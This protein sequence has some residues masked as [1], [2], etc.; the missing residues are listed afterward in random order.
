M[1]PPNDD[2]LLRDMR[3]SARKAVA[4]IQGRS[5][6]DLERDPVLNAALERF[7]EVVGEAANR[8]S[9]DRKK[10]LPGIPWR[11]IVAMRNRLVHGY[12][13]VD[14]DVLWDVVHDDLSQTDR[15]LGHRARRVMKI[16]RRLSGTDT[17]ATRATAERG[18]VA[19]GRMPPKNST[20]GQATIVQ[21]LAVVCL[22]IAASTEAACGHGFVV[23]VSTPVSPPDGLEWSWPMALAVLFLVNLATFRI[24]RWWGWL[25]SGFRAI[26]AIALFAAIFF[27]VGSC[28]ETVQPR[29]LGIPCHI[30]WGWGWTELG[31]LF[32]GWNTISSFALVLAV[33]AASQLWKRPRKTAII[34]IGINLLVYAALCLPYITSGALAQGWVGAYARTQCSDHLE[35]HMQA[36]IHYAKEHQGKLP[37]AK[38]L[39][40]LLTELRPYTRQPNLIQESPLDTCPV[41]A[42][43]ERSP[44]RYTWNAWYAGRTV[45][46]M[47]DASLER[48]DPI[49]CPYHGSARTV[50]TEQLMEDTLA[51][52]PEW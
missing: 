10:A 25:Q 8:V 26:G 32:V 35:L 49:R 30:Y 31:G 44:Q 34:A 47:R 5:R 33:A 16:H 23:Y 24:M 14:R 3:D 1:S 50:G 21:H 7:V 6:A 29:S 22:V 38:T 15:A 2:T 36:M 4:A 45:R 11:Q 9:E 37:D 18:D 52:H 51:A 27:A 28:T 43:F 39:D 19:E 20:S 42:A 41:G 40:E 17:D 48:G 12:A 46:E 13:S